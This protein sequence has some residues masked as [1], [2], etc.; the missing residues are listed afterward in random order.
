MVL[1]H[2]AMQMHAARVAR[3][4]ALMAVS[5]AEQQDELTVLVSLA[6]AGTPY[7]VLIHR[8]LRLLGQESRHYGVSLI[9][10]WGIDHK[11]LDFIRSQHSHGIIHF[12]DGWTG[13]GGISRELE[14]SVIEY[15]Q[16]RGT[17]LCT[18]L[19][20]LSDLAG[21]AGVAINC[22][23]YL[24]PS[25][26]INAPMNGLISKTFGEPEMTSPSGF[27]GTYL[28]Q[29]LADVDYSQRFIDGIAE[30]LPQA[31]ASLTEHRQPLV[32][33]EQKASAWQ[34]NELSMTRLQALYSIRDEDLIKHGYCETV[35]ALQRRSMRCLL[36]RHLSEQT[37]AIVALAASLDLPVYED[38]DLHYECVGI[39]QA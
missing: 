23:D 22:D 11:A 15:N 18:K 7:G 30:L 2:S 25:A 4:V 26:L 13:K 36:L 16:E 27:H 31:L 14:R 21:T 10:G 20:V 35:R 32:D 19:N 5:I 3:D 17:T 39:C 34:R 8:A 29:H 28:L 9:K 33:S 38:K 24:I 6:R 37:E 1:F 12:I